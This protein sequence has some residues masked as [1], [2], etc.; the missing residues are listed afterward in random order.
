MDM[1]E[2]TDMGAWFLQMCFR[3]PEFAKTHKSFTQISAQ[4]S[5][6][7]PIALSGPV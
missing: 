1:I 7:F 4:Q 3:Y 2:R 6:Q 5:F